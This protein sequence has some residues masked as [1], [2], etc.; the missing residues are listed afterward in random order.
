M[1][2]TEILVTALNSNIENWVILNDF[3]CYDDFIDHCVELFEGVE[4]PELIFKDKIGEKQLFNLITE[5]E[6]DPEIWDLLNCEDPDQILALMKAK[7]IGSPLDA[8]NYHDENFLGEYY[9]D[10]KFV[11]E[12]EGFDNS[13][14]DHIH[15]NWEK[16][17]ED[18]MS[19]YGYMEV[20][21]H[22]YKDI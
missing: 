19:N 5:S 4:S 22:Y 16:T 18:V 14:P 17:A 1:K 15:I 8:I 2:K 20:E 9:S 6:I 7:N 21:G 12:S 10:T 13:V 3:D 11:Q